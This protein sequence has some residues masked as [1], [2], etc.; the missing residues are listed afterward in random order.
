MTPPSISSARAGCSRSSVCT[1]SARM[2]T[3]SLASESV[4]PSSTVCLSFDFDAMSVWFVSEHVT[5]AML[6]RGEYGARVGVPRLLQL[7]D[8]RDLPATFFVP[9]HTIES[10][11]AQTEAIAAAGHELAHHSYAHI[12]PSTQQPAEERA[13]ME[14]ALATFDRIGVRPAGFRSPSADFSAV[15][16][17]LLEELGFTYDSSLMGDDYRPYRPRVGDRVGRH[18]PLERGR[19]ARLWELPMS[20]ELDDWPHFQFSFR[21]YQRGLAAP[22]A[23]LEIWT[24]EFDWMDAHVDG[25]VLVVCMHPQVIGRGHRMAMLERFIEHCAAAGARF[26]RLGDVAAELPRRVR[27]SAAHLRVEGVEHAARVLAVQPHVQVEVDR[28]PWAVACHGTV[29]GAAEQPRPVG[30]RGQILIGVGTHVLNPDQ[31]H[32]A[33]LLQVEEVLWPLEIE[34]R[35]GQQLRVHVVDAHPTEPGLGHARTGRDIPGG[36]RPLQLAKADGRLAGRGEPLALVARCVCGGI[37]IARRAGECGRRDRRRQPAASSAG[38]A[39]RARQDNGIRP[40][41]SVARSKVCPRRRRHANAVPR[42]H[43]MPGQATDA[44]VRIF[45]CRRRRGATIL[46]RLAHTQRADVHN[47]AAARPNRAAP[48]P[49]ANTAACASAHRLAAQ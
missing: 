6:Q 48:S 39:I 4:M 49:H 3:G 34:L 27:R 45:D 41:T 9:G 43:V 14:R 46:D 18:E 36:L 31:P 37:A 19:E 16:L 10:F 35:I 42:G 13:D 38:A 12:N 17:E 24:E 28:L 22:S 8:E 21:P 33:V 20:F 40:P 5:P 29:E 11:P 1:P 2:T 7:L 15:T 44:A 30:R 25:G 26:R 47:D 32:A 23:V